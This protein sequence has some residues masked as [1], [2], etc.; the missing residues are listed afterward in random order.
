MVS[1]QQEKAIILFDGVCNF[2]NGAINFIIRHDSQNR[3]QFAPLQSELGQKYV[4]DFGLYDI[5]SV[6]L[7]KDGR[8]FTHSSA[9]LEIARHLDG[10]WSWFYIFR[11]VPRALRD[12]CYRLFARYR[13]KLFGKQEVCMMPTP[14]VR[15]R[16]LS[17]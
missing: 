14:E 15:A 12:F 4:R 5:D 2:C 3:F 10:I 9:A 13:Y 17:S 1:T 11:F 8:A 6:I 7:V 16:F